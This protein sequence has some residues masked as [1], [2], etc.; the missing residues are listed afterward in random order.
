M[1]ID[2]A[3]QRDI[4]PD[5]AIITHVKLF[6][7][8]GLNA[9]LEDSL[10]RRMDEVPH[11][12]RIL[13][14]ELSAFDDYLKSLEMLPL[15]ADIRQQAEAIRIAELEKTLRRMPDLTDTERERIA[16]LTHSLVK[17]ILDRPTRR[18]RAE[19]SCPHAPAFATVARTLFELKHETGTC[20]LSGEACSISPAAD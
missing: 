15:I 11:V 2:I 18:L 3:V 17:K 5:A 1:L 20:G 12:K 9:Q 16:A 19:S 8:D 13:E 6:D 7:I 10:A 14:Q 4:D